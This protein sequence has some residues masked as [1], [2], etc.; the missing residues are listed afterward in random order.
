MYCRKCGKEIPEDSK[1]CP[2]CGEQLTEDN[3]KKDTV[4]GPNKTSAKYKKN[5]LIKYS[6]IA[7]AALFL[8]SFILLVMSVW[9]G[10]NLADVIGILFIVI[11]IVAIILVIIGLVC[12]KRDYVSPKIKGSVIALIVFCF[13]GFVFIPFGTG[14]LSSDGQIDNNDNTPNIKSQSK[15]QSELVG[16]WESKTKPKITIQLQSDGKCQITKENLD[17]L[18]L[19]TYQDF[20]YKINGDSLSTIDKQGNETKYTYSFN[21]LNGSR[22]LVLSQSSGVSETYYKIK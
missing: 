18:L 15:I 21:N 3:I 13:L 2:E 10:K 7:Y 1:F 11:P 16:T 4:V 20:Q 12:L 9:L 17:P 6:I 5:K 14:I 8:L 22:A 19:D